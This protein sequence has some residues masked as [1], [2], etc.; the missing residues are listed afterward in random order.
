[1]KGNR[2]KDIKT[3]LVRYF[4]CVFSVLAIASLICGIE[5]S[6]EKSYFRM[7]GK[8]YETV[9]FSELN[10]FLQQFTENSGI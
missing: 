6:G 7:T 10:N 3:V 4:I 5:Y 2:N 8:H 9:N 1:M